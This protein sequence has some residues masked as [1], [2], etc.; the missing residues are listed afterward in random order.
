MHKF[1]LVKQYDGVVILMMG[2]HSIAIRLYS[3]IIVSGFDAIERIRSA[4]SRHCERDEDVRSLTVLV[5]IE[6]FALYSLRCSMCFALGVAVNEFSLFVN[7]SYEVVW[8]LDVLSSTSHFL[9]AI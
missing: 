2:N 1:R 9:L 3:L 4:I 5:I 7:F 8:W 6:S